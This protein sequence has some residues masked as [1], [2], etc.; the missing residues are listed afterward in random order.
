LVLLPF[1]ARLRRTGRRWL[2]L[3]VIASTVAISIGVSACGGITYT[4]RS[5]TLTI[6]GQAGDLSHSTTVKVTIE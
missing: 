5:Y 4:P 1:A 3:A 6:K 2:L